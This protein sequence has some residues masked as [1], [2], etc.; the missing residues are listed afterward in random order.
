MA[1]FKSFGTGGSIPGNEVAW[2]GTYSE[3][4]VDG[5][6]AVPEEEKR[7]GREVRDRGERESTTRGRKQGRTGLGGKV[8]AETHGSSSPWIG[9]G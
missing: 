3:I 6:L 9:H 4:L 5:D 1:G 2:G 7:R 8:D